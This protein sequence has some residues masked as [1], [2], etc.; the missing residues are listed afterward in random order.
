[1]LFETLM[2]KEILLSVVGLAFVTCLIISVFEMSSKIEFM[3]EE[4]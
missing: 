2:T 4:D 1:M 3:G